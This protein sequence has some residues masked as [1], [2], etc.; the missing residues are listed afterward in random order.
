MNR[1]LWLVFGVPVKDEDIDKVYVTMVGSRTPEDTFDFLR[2]SASHNTEKSG[3]LLGAQ[4]IFV[5]VDIFAIDHGWPRSAIL[6]SLLLLLAGSL[7]VMTNLRSTLGAYGRLERIDAARGI[8]NMILSRTVRF[9]I[10]LYLTFLSI[11]LLAA[12]TFKFI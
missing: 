12:A 11:L 9:N 3:A 6:A 2:T 7:V 5:V 8:F 10:A 4:G 1:L